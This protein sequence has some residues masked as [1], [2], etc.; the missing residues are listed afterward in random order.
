MSQVKQDNQNALAD[1]LR[2]FSE[3]AKMNY[4]THAFEAGY[5]QSTLVS[6]LPLLPKR[7]Q[8]VLIDDIARAAQKQSAFAFQKQSDQIIAKMSKKA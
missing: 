5:L 8:K 4:G 7:D 2:A 3:A 1:V 6:I